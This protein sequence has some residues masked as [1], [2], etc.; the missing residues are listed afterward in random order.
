MFI[1]DNNM[2]AE[3]ISRLL[4]QYSASPNL[5][6]LITAIVEQIQAIEVALTPMN[7]ER[8]LPGAQG[9]QLDIIGSIIGVSRP[10]G[11][12]DAQ[13]LVLIYAQIKQNTSQGQ[14]EQVIQLFLLLTGVSF[15]FYGE[16]EN[17]EF[18]VG[19][20]YLPPNQAAV[21]SLINLLEAIGPAGVRC[22]GIITFDADIPFAYDGNLI[23]SGYDDG[24]QTVGGLMAQLFEY[25]GPGFAYAD[26]PI[27]HLNG[28]GGLTNPLACTNGVPLGYGTLDDPLAFGAYLI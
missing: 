11:Y 21:D 25:L 2:V 24:T 19:S 9:A 14:P 23:G 10:A 28:P 7:T 18:L 12:T 6:G 16:G 13:Y 8:Y 15:V 26:E 20:T 17:S 5:Q 22:D 1:Q 27:G 4:Y 3:A